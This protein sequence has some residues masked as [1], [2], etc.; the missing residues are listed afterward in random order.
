MKAVK[1]F[2]LFLFISNFGYGQ[3]SCSANAGGPRTVCTEQGITLFGAEGDGYAQP[4]EVNWVAGGGNPIPTVIANPNSLITPV[5]PGPGFNS[6]PPGVY[7]FTLF[8]TCDDMDHTVSNETVEITVAEVINLPTINPINPNICGSSISLT[9]SPA[10]PGVITNWRIE[11]MDGVS[12]SGS[13]SSATVSKLGG[14]TPCTYTVFY[15]HSA[16]VC[17]EETSTSFTFTKEYTQL[18]PAV[19]SPGCPSCTRT[20]TLGEGSLGCGGTPV[21]SVTGTP[22]GVSANEV[23]IGTPNSSTTSVTVPADGNYTFGYTIENGNCTTTAASVS[24]TIQEEEGFEVGPGAFFTTCE[25]MWNITSDDLAGNFMT[26]VTYQWEV[27]FNT[28]PGVDITFSNPNSAATTV[29]F[30]GAPVDISADGGLVGVRLTSTSGN[31]TDMADFYYSA[32]P[33]VTVNAEEVFLLC[34]DNENYMP[35]TNLNY[36]NGTLGISTTITIIDPPAASI[37]TSGQEFDLSTNP[38][39]NLSAEGTYT[40]EVDIA[41]TN[42]DP[43]GN[44]VTCTA[45]TDFTVFVAEVPSIEAGANI[46]TCLLTTSLNG[47]PPI[48]IEGNPIDIPVLWTQ[49]GGPEVNIINPDTENPAITGMQNGETYTFQYSYSTDPSCPFLDIMTV[50]V[51]PE[52]E[53][54]TPCELEISIRQECREG[55]TQLNVS[56]ATT[57]FWTPSSGVDDVTSANPIICSSSGGVYTVLGYN[58]SGELCGSA[59]Y[60]LPPCAGQPLSC[61]IELLA[62]CTK[63]SCG[64][65]YGG[66]RLLDS[67]GNL[68]ND[69]EAEIQWNFDGV[70]VGSGQNPMYLPYVSPMV[71]TATVAVVIDGILCEFTESVAVTCLD[72]CPEV[73]FVTCRDEEAAEFP[74]CEKQHAQNPCIEGGFFGYVWALDAAGNLMD[75][76]YVD[77]YDDNFVDPNPIFISNWSNAEDCGQIPVNIWSWGGCD[78]TI[79]FDTDCCSSQAPEIYCG[80]TTEGGYT[81]YW[82]PV[83]GAQVY[84]VNAFCLN[85]SYNVTYEVPADQTSSTIYWPDYCDV[86]VVTVQALCSSGAL[87][88]HSNC[89]LISE[90]QGCSR[91]EGPCYFVETEGKG[92]GEGEGK[93]GGK[94]RSFA[95]E[96]I[97][98]QEAFKAYPNPVADDFVQI[99]V[100]SI[101]WLVHSSLDIQLFDVNGRLVKQKTVTDGSP[102]QE[103]QVGDINNGLFLLTIRNQEGQLLESTRLI[104]GMN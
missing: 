46:T 35:S 5:S 88:P 44:E 47:N 84:Y 20:I 104:K 19:T 36:S 23:I 94:G 64:A 38:D 80:E 41:V 77:W 70:D 1:L 99:D 31:C 40:F 37:Y 73:H 52:N 32:F 57:Y 15:T 89:L 83:C 8:V 98:L 27:L 69:N 55:C 54:P 49:V 28:L 60:D 29:N 6:F 48:D 56:G 2:I 68:L 96:D 3:A 85:N 101:H 17:V 51:L 12:I 81:A 14:T 53:C 62:V 18:F 86:M 74:E 61:D 67:N 24:C 79:Y 25:D 72:D 34:G 91:V 42:F 100:P 103:L 76:F 93:D 4:L 33:N 9:G 71:V 13:G 22:N 90:K 43:L 30:N 82:E 102:R 65:P 95:V 75:N 21:W 97:V 39:F 87:S 92:K 50:T 7:S 10:D 16:G 78:E 63:C 26:G 66:G 11:P 45:Q 58:A 59:V